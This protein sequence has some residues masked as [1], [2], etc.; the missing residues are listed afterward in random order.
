MGSLMASAA[1]M[2]ALAPSSA[3]AQAYT[4]TG[5]A[6]GNQDYT[7]TLGENFTVTSAINVSSLGAFVG[8][9]GASGDITTAIFDDSTG[10][11][12]ALESINVAGGTAGSYVYQNLSS[13]VVLAAGNYQLESWGYG[14]NDPNYNSY[15]GS[16]SI[17]FAGVGSDVTADSTA[18]SAQAGT[19]ASQPD[20]GAT[21]YGAGNFI[22]TAYSGPPLPPSPGTAVYTTQSGLAGNQAF[23][24]TLGLE[25][26]VNGKPISIS[27][28]GAFDS[29]AGTITAPIQAEL[30]DVTTH[31]FVAGT[32][33]SFDGKGDPTGAAYVF[34]ALGSNVV[35]KAGTYEILSWGYN[36]T[37][38]DYNTYGNNPGPIVFNGLG[39]DLTADGSFYNNDPDAV[40][41][42]TDVGAMRYGAGT[43]I[44]TV[45][46]EP[47]TWAMM[48]AGFGFM[49][50]MIRG[51]RRKQSNAPATA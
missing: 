31:S 33:V 2:V 49:G 41:D 7:G 14:A 8:A 3:L 29:V 51:S 12:V 17:S 28:L 9:S 19:Y 18:Y 40:P 27:Q 32:L 5:G 50:F 44:A 25:F 24:G 4:N 34:Q 6:I 36:S 43:F 30:Y 39:G 42:T 1:L 47:A 10:Q 16:S 21:R 37:D 20:V 26:T 23:T 22:A 13:G 48:L 35:L 45:V 15:G 46:P 38:E 11:I